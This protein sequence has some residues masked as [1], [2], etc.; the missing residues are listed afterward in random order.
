MVFKFL[1]DN[2]LE[3]HVVEEQGQGNLQASCSKGSPVQRP[4]NRK[5][6][7]LVLGLQGTD[8]YY[9]KEALQTC[10]RS[11]TLLCMRKGAERS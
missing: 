3:W 7:L 8:N 9:G 2:I 4:E 11:W 6:D 5:T 10:K 1:S